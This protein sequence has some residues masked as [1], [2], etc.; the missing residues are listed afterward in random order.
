VTGVDAGQPTVVRLR[1]GTEHTHALQAMLPERRVIEEVA[2][3]DEYLW[4][5]LVDE[6]KVL[7]AHRALLA[8]GCAYLRAAFAFDPAVR[9][10]AYRLAK[11]ILSRA[12]Q[13]GLRRAHV[14]VETRGQEGNMARLLGVSQS[15]TPLH[16]YRLPRTACVGSAPA[17][18]TTDV[19]WVRDGRCLVSHPSFGADG[20]PGPTLAEVPGTPPAHL[21]AETDEIEVAFP[22]SD[23]NLALDLR[24]RGARR[25][26]RVP[27]MH[28]IVNLGGG[29]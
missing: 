21:L 19:L 24:R 23:I 8:N 29:S 25:M 14:W 3:T 9:F 20:L 5:A 15:T 2:A 11:A 7:G 17:R 12:E 6:H 28:G 22:A 26:S 13:S 18:P 16:R 27:V 10:L 4:V 1:A